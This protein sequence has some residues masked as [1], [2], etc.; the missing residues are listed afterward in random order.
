MLSR[1]AHIFT[2]HRPSVTGSGNPA[3][4]RVWGVWLPIICTFAG[5]IFAPWGWASW[6]IYPLQM[7]RQTLRGT[8]GLRDRSIKSIFQVVGRFPEGWGQ[9]RFMH[10]YLLSRQAPLIEY[11]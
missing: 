10:D 5:L 3:E 1:K 8:G 7:L 9:I 4:P 2:A 6:G 11:K